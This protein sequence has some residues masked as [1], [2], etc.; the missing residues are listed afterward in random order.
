M[1]RRKLIPVKAHSQQAVYPGLRKQKPFFPDIIDNITGILL[2]QV[3]DD[4][5]LIGVEVLQHKIPQRSVFEVS[6]MLDPDPHPDKVIA[7]CIHDVLDP[8]VSGAPTACFQPDPAKFN[9][10]VIMEHD[11]VP[12]RKPVAFQKQLDRFPTQIHV[13]HGF[14]KTQRLLGIER[15]GKGP[16]H[17]LGQSHPVHQKV[18][19]HKAGIVPGKPVFPPRISQSRDQPVTFF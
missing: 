1:M 12:G 7:D 5:M 14:Y 2:D 4:L 15:I 8:V 10:L 3:A 13:H 18:H 6:R 16:L 17:L 19:C 9:I 11:D